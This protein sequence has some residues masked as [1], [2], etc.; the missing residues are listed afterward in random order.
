VDLAAKLA[1]KDGAPIGEVFAFISGLYFR[2]KLAYVTA[3]G[4]S[5]DA[6]SGA[7]VITPSRGLVDVNTHVTG[8]VLD[9]FAAVDVHPDN[10]RYRGPLVRD[11]GALAQNPAI[12]A[13]LLGSI[14]SEKYGSLLL[15]LLGPRLLFPESFVGRGDMSRGGVMLRAARDRTELT[16]VPLEGA[17][18]RGARPPKLPPLPV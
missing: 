10:P 18:R 12:S 16:Y 8:D 1:S 15:P 17:T 7:F 9:E 3:F 5:S 11:I 14:A 6:S 4:Q 13:V 2:G